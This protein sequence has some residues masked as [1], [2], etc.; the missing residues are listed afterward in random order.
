[1]NLVGCQDQL[2]IPQGSDT[3]DGRIPAPVNRW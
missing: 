2:E 3:V 1:M